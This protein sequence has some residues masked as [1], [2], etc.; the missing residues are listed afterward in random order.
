MSFMNSNMYIHIQVFF[1]GILEQ[2]HTAVFLSTLS[3]RCPKVLG[4]KMR[5]HS[6]FSPHILV[7]KSSIS[8]ITGSSA[9]TN[10][11]PDYT[12]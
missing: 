10:V 9:M 3:P 12:V 1:R 8:C 4:V 11:Y 7:C 5:C 2:S 6:S